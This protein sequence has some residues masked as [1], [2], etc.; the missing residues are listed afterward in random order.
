M[1]EYQIFF[2]VLQNEYKRI[3]GCNVLLLPIPALIKM[4]LYR[5]RI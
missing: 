4:M 3:V 5:S 2:E 1:S